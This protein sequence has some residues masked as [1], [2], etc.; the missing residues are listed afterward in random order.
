MNVGR[1]ATIDE[2]ALFHALKTR[3]IGG[4]VID[5]WYEYPSAASPNTL[6]SKLPFHELESVLMTPHMS[7][8]T[9]G[10]VR[11]RQRTIAANVERLMKGQPCA[12]VVYSAHR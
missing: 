11:R 6:P 8:W 3:R 4:A 5:T 12:D 1:G 7:A 2:N 10:T 9:H